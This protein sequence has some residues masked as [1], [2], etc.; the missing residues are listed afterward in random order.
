MPGEESEQIEN[1]YESQSPQKMKRLSTIPFAFCHRVGFAWWLRFSLFNLLQAFCYCP[2]Y[3][4]WHH[5]C[6]M[7]L[8]RGYLNLSS[9]DVGI[10][11]CRLGRKRLRRNICFPASTIHACTVRF[12]KIRKSWRPMRTSEGWV[13]FTVL[14]SNFVSFSVFLINWTS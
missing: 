11:D 10:F 13:D 7:H 12:K 8:W 14:S 3:H 1:T 4:L 6:V 2:E 5:Y 9:P